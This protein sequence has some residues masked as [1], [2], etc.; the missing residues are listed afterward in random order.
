MSARTR[1]IAEIALACAALLGCALSWLHARAP[2]QVAPVADG[3]PVT[4][5]VV[6]DP[7][8]LLLTLLLATA[9]GVLAVVGTARLRRAQRGDE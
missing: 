5:S 3:Q 8:L 4:T 9:A 6:Y 7:P 2:V 1:A